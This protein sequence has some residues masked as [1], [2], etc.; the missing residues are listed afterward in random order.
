MIS[1]DFEAHL[2]PEQLE[3][4]TLIEGPVLVIA[5][6]GSGK[7][8]TLV[9]RVANLIGQGV[10]PGSILLLTFTRKAA[11][12]MLRRAGELVGEQSALVTG[13]TF[14]S[15]CY[16]QL[17]MYS[18]VLG[19][20]SHFTVLDRG[21]MEDLLALLAKELGFATEGQ[22]FPKKG[23]LA[24]ICSK[25]MNC[26]KDTEWVLNRGYPQY[27]HL[28]PT[29]DALFEAYHEYKRRHALMDYDDLLIN[30]KRTLELDSRI[31]DMISNR[32]QFIMVDE[33]QDTNQ[34]QAELIRLMATTHDNVMAVGDDAQSIYSFRGANFKNI[35]EFPRMFPGT[36]IIKLERNYRTHQPNLDCTNAIIANAKEKFTKRLT[37]VKDGGEPPILYEAF[38][39]NDQAE[40][41][42]Q[43]IRELLLMGKDPAEIA[44]LFR[45]GF[46]S[47]QLEGL[48]NRYGIGYVKRGGLKLLE[49]AHIKDVLSFLKII[50]NPLDILALRRVFTLVPGLGEKGVQ[51]I[52]EAMLRADDPLAAVLEFN[53]RARWGR[54][55]KELVKHI[56]E[57]RDQGSSLE[58]LFESLSNLYEP[59]LRSRYPDDYPR[60]LQELEELM[61]I[62]G[63]FE[64]IGEFLTEMALDPPDEE[65]AYG[66]QECV[67]LSTVHSAKGLEWDVVFVISLAEGRFPSPMALDRDEDLEEE[68]RLFYVAATRAK[69]RLYLVYPRWIRVSHGGGRP[70]RPSRFLE[71]I[72]TGLIKKWDP[73]PEHMVKVRAPGG[74]LGVNGGVFSAGS[75]VRHA[76]FGPGTV[77]RVLDRERIAVDFDDSG[78]KIINIGI[79]RLSPI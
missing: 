22:V 34:V 28:A 26:M 17:R 18:H 24:T 21:D 40:F 41:V 64:E 9:F 75:R 10:D 58:E 37:A 38:D 55:L 50:M 6:A 15:F 14:H 67:C 29:L 57:L 77:T 59:I 43:R 62:A 54:P 5:G 78:Q 72:P 42:S 33:Y 13:G 23:G 60:R 52:Y 27:V 61:V 48:L 25:R 65:E 66:K 20:P 4:V 70:G 2:N 31:R 74:R 30:W 7:T 56:M 63:N 49:G 53:T 36:H 11:Q 47:F 51:R 8:R 39:E 79:A 35:I 12:E 76:L 16:S 71:E 69:D 1:I 3:A 45:A 32:Y 68:R 19:Y 44:V 46:H 73:V